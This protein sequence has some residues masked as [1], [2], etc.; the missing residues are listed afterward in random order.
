MSNIQLVSIN[1]IPANFAVQLPSSKSMSN[2]A[3]ILHQ[4]SKGKITIGNLSDARDTQI[5]LDLLN[6]QSPILNAQDAGTAFRFLVAWA[7][8]ENKN[9]IITGTERMKQRPIKPL[10]EALR[11]LGFRLSY[12]ENEGFP[13]VQITPINDFKLLK[14]EV[15]IDAT[16]SSQ[17]VSALMMIAPIF[18]N[19]LKIKL[20]GSAISEPYLLLTQKML[21]LCKINVV[22]THNVI[23]IPA[24]P[25]Q[26]AH[27]EIEP[28][29]TNAFYWIA[30]CA[31]I[32]NSKIKLNNL[33]LNSLQGDAQAIKFLNLFGVSLEQFPTFILVKNNGFAFPVNIQLQLNF[34]AY[35]D[36]AQTF[37]VLCA[38]KNMKVTFTG[39]STLAI[40]ETNRIVAMQNEL[41]KCGV[42]LVQ[43]ATDVYELNGHFQLPNEAIETYNDH[44]MAMSFAPLAALGN[45]TIN[46]S[47]VVAK[48]YP[49]FWKE[50]CSLFC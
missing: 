50:W 42:F 11:S 45:I 49:N 47:E 5:L 15:E 32:P 12:P 30:L 20:K 40:K 13:P 44:R 6:S 7:C 27:F 8:V 48:S 29:W 23:A 2:R 24:M 39:L 18:P 43:T 22:F 35:P 17:F 31:L 10:V 34:S 9:V 38:A 16:V 46:H 14:N 26:A 1:K 4:L 3:L 28:D 33:R 36:L 41:K 37:M 25:L 21:Q 19:G